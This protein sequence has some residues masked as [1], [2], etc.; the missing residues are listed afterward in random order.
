MKLAKIQRGAKNRMKSSTA[1]FADSQISPAR[2]FASYYSN[3]ALGLG[4][5]LLGYKRGVEE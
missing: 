3:F 1:E 2:F 4:I 5:S